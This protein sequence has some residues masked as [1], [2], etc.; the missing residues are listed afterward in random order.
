MFLSL[1]EPG[2]YLLYFLLWCRISGHTY[3][4]KFALFP[5]ELLVC[6][7]YS[8]GVQIKATTDMFQNQ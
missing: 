6:T 8:P 7:I 1:V 4:I 2:M 3:T 5:N